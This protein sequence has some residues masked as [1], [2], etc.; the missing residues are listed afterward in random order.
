MKLT[1]FSFAIVTE[2]CDKA[3]V[4]NQQNCQYQITWLEMEEYNL[5]WHVSSSFPSNCN[6]LRTSGRELF[7]PKKS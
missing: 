3:I 6:L 5:G 4:S 7:T 1:D 2:T